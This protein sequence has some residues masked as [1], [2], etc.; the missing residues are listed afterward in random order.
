MMEIANK[1]KAS[2]PIYFESHNGFI[3][4]HISVF[5]PQF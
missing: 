5:L 1:E 3:V 4:I 2:F